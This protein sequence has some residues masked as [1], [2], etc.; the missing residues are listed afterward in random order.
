MYDVALSFTRQTDGSDEQTITVTA[1][2]TNYLDFGSDG[3]FFEPAYLHIRVLDAFESATSG[4]TLTVALQSDDNTSFSSAATMLTPVS[5]VDHSSLTAGY[6]VV[7]PFP[8]QDLEQY[9]RLYFTASATMT[10]GSIVA[11]INDSPEL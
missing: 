2:S 8:I 1:A 9:Y 4:A 7:V 10:T 3:N 5:A 6:H 11:Y